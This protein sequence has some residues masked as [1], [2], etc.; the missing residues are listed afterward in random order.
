MVSAPELVDRVHDLAHVRDPRGFQRPASA[1]ISGLRTRSWS[2]HS[3][4]VRVGGGLAFLCSSSAVPPLWPG[5]STV[6]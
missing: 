6:D 4:T 5:R 3:E 1:A 2:A